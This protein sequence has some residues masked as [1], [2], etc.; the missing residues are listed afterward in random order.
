MPAKIRN[1]QGV[2][3]LGN[4]ID[5]WSY[6]ST[7]DYS[8]NY[9]RKSVAVFEFNK[10]LEYKSGKLG[11]YKAYEL[12]PGVVKVKVKAD[13]NFDGKFSKDELIYKH[14]IKNV[15]DADKLINFEGTIKL[16]KQMHSCDWEIQKNPENLACTADYIPE[17]T[18]LRLI[19]QD[20]GS[21]FD[22]PVYSTTDWSMH[23][24][25][26]EAQSIGGGGGAGGLIF[27]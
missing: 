23:N 19:H 20:I 3:A 26:N 9:L 8:P 4:Y 21:L 17:Y 11:K 10:S 13:L 2:V 1:I 14:K 25:G 12:S 24:L 18:D 27:G 15:E 22:F 5:P 6:K 16:R 7:S